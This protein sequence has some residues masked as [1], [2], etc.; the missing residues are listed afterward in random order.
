MKKVL[1]IIG[2]LP[3]RNNLII[4]NT[5]SI[6]LNNYSIHFWNLSNRVRFNL[7]DSFRK[8]LF[9][10]AS[11][12]NLHKL[13]KNLNISYS[14]LCHLKLGKYSIPKENLIYLSDKTGIKKEEV[15]KNIITIRTRHGNKSNVKLPLQTSEKIASL[16]GHIYGDGFISAKKRQMEYSNTNKDLIEEV[17]MLVKDVFGIKPYTKKQ[18]RL[19]FSSIVGEFLIL[20]GAPTSPK[21][22][23]YK[24]LP[25][26]LIQGNKECKKYFL[27][28]IFDDDGSVMFSENYNAKGINL[29][30]TIQQEN[31]NKLFNLLNQ[32]KS[33]LNDFDVL[34]SEPIKRKSYYK[35]GKEHIVMYITITDYESI[36]NFS[37]AIGFTN[38]NKQLKLEKILSRKTNPVKRQRLKITQKIVNLLKTNVSLSTAEL[39]KLLGLPKITTYKKMNTLKKNKIVVDVEQINNNRSYIWKLLEVN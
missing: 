37:K 38:K 31:K 17:E 25:E 39:A 12:G 13:A 6:M 35:K 20:L 4:K 36:L 32:I 5:N 16:V 19:C 29:H 18:D 34:S 11:K 7:L 10:K 22:Q 23:N 27:R 3:F 8:D 28:A 30:W 26:W 14:Y 9:N 1:L 33:L 2:N 21:T 24:K 15:E